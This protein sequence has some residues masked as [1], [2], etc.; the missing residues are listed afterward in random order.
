MDYFEVRLSLQPYRPFCEIL[1]AQLAEIGYESFLEEEHSS[2]LKAY[3]PEKEYREEKI[4]SLLRQ[5][6]KKLKC[7]FSYC[8]IPKE[9]WNQKWEAS[10]S[11]VE[12]ADFCIVRAPF[13]Q[14]KSG[15]Q[16][17]LII[18]PKMS[19]GTAHHQTTQ[20]M[21]ELMQGLNLR[22]QSV[23]DMGSG[24]GILAILAAKLGAETID[25]IDIEDWA[26]ENMQENFQ[27]NQ[28]S[29]IKAQLGNVSL[30]QHKTK[31]YDVIFANINKNTLLADLKHYHKAL[32][33]DGHLLLSGFYFE[34][35]ADLMATSTLK[36][37]R[38]QKQLQKDKWAAL[39]LQKGGV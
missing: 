9:N 20:M 24:T 37:Y 8:S 14:P 25:A 36:S 38:K 27:R 7:S 3:I 26:F 30:I 33:T 19:F 12:L 22:Q 32:K 5:H 28:C 29:F 34:D 31:A 17:E 21:L 6:Q 11:P 1:I 35:V 23:L 4:E 39:H 10:F 16:H 13:H 15:F 18:E 2:C